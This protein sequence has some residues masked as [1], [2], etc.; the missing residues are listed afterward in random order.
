MGTEVKV[1]QAMFVFG[2][3]SVEARALVCTEPP[4]H[5]FHGAQL[6]R[7]VKPL[8]GPKRHASFENFLGRLKTFLFEDLTH[9]LFL[10]PA[11]RQLFI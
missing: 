10:G 2:E 9:F 5:F 8:T 1:A 6:A 11:L 4:F 7:M 3:G